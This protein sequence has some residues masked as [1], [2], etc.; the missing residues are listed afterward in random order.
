VYPHVSRQ[1]VER[2]ELGRVVA[3]ASFV[4]PA[5]SS[6]PRR[7]RGVPI[8]R[9]RVVSTQTRAKHR[10]SRRRARASR[11]AVAR[12]VDGARAPNERTPREAKISRDRA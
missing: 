2:A 11:S 4:I 6:T 10:P 3:V 7:R 8:A 5:A 1:R 12:R 9:A